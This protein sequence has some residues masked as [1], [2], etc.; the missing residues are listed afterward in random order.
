MKKNLLLFVLL[1]LISGVMFGQEEYSITYSPDSNKPS[2][3]C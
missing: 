3:C 2:N 1:L